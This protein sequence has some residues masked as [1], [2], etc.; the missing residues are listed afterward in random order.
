[1]PAV[2]LARTTD[3]ALL[4]GAMAARFSPGRQCCAAPIAGAGKYFDS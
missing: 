3:I 4:A 1:M 2:L